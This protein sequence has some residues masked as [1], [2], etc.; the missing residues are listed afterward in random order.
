MYYFVNHIRVVA[1]ADDEEEG[2]FYY[3]YHVVDE[4]DKVVKGS[5]WTHSNNHSFHLYY[6]WLESRD[7]KIQANCEISQV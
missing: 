6:A 3:E 7:F 4:N 5:R 1:R 2:D